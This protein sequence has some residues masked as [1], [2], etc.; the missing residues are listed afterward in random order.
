MTNVLS[1]L[2]VARFALVVLNT[3]R[4]NLAFGAKEHIENPA[5]FFK[6]LYKYFSIMRCFLLSLVEGLE[7]SIVT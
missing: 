3:C 4:P 6:A 1:F 2:P 7:R 5:P